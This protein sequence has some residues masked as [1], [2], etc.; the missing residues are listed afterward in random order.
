MKGLVFNI[1]RFSI[2]DGPGIRTTVFLK[3]CPLRCA[4]C[5]NPESHSF[6]P[7]I[8]FDASKCI[9]CGACLETC[10]N[11]LLQDG[12]HI[13]DRS[14]CKSCGKCAEACLSDALELCGKYMTDTEV[15]ETVLRDKAFYQNNGGMTLSGGEPLMQHE[16][17]LSLLKLAKDSGIHT[18][19]ETS[20]FGSVEAL[21]EIAEYTDLFLYDIK[22]TDNEQHLIY[23][24][25]SPERILHN[26]ELLDE[27]N[28]QI[29]LRCPM[30]P[31]V[32]LTKEH[33][34]NVFALSEKFSSVQSIE[35][36]PY[37]P[38]GVNKSLLIGKVSSY[39]SS[40]FL[41]K[42]AIQ[43]LIDDSGIEHAKPYSIH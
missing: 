22:H 1:Q 38:L 41:E 9:G 11:H 17:S 25:V 27:I 10:T 6:T 18:A 29:I 36:E 43:K 35:F 8:M 13:L 4:W 33:I 21:R 5:H 24:G 28:K 23:T 26:L 14:K 3:G 19:V 39:L 15:F 20:G 2:D 16:F 32:N 42:E 37:H 40:E 7:E 34:K 30:I 31:G 12:I